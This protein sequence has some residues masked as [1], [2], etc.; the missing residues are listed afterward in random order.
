MAKKLSRR[1]RKVTNQIPDE[2]VN[3][4]AHRL[5]NKDTNSS[6]GAD[7]LVYGYPLSEIKGDLR[8]SLILFVAI[9]TTVVVLKTTP[10]F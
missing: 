8:K 4:N 9:I 3:K 7:S 6:F 10:W 2:G 5:G 1:K